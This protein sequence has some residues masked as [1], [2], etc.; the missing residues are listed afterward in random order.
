MSIQEIKQ[1][2]PNQWVLL[3]NPEMH[4]PHVL[5]GIVIFYAPTK[6][7]LIA[8]R[9]LLKSFKRSTWTFTGEPKRGTSQWAAI[10]R[11]LPNPTIEA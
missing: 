1:H 7:G 9:D 6:Q 10:F 8:G 3:G 4:G 5:G 11:Q 2:Y